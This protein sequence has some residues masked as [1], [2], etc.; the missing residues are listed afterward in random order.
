MTQYSID[1]FE[2]FGV[3][4]DEVT[5]FGSRHPG[6]CR[7]DKNC[8]SQFLL[9]Q[10]TSIEKYRVYDVFSVTDVIEELEGVGRGCKVKENQF[11]HLPLKGF[12]K[13]HFFDTQFLAQNLINQLGLEFENSTK[14]SE[15]CSR[16]VEEEKRYPS[17]VGWQGRL[18]HA[19]TI[20]A[21]EE[22]AKK[23]RLTG[24][25]IIFSKFNNKNYYLCISRHTSQ[26]GDQEI[27]DFLQML[28]ENEYPFLKS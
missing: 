6:L 18:A 23:N 7:I 15:L 13:I 27:A 11:K 3:T 24:E 19:M 1:V 8:V 14:F 28:C 12:W 2:S 26:S 9:I 17:N 16:M 20:G 25:W 4:E 21:Y 10:L 5:Q 22:R